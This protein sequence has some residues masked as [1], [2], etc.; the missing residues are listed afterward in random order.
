MKLKHKGM[1]FG[2]GS[3]E[4]ILLDEARLG[5]FRN[6]NNF[7]YEHD[8]YVIGPEQIEEDVSVLV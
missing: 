1:I 2:R 4:N 6:L 8:V 7:L 5:L 3:I